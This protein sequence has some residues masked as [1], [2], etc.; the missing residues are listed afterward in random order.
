MASSALQCGLKNIPIELNLVAAPEPIAVLSLDFHCSKRLCNLLANRITICIQVGVL[1]RPQS[2][3]G[4]LHQSSFLIL[5]E[6]PNPN[7]LITSYLAY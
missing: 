3:K 4:P 1:K 5:T 6:L 7:P 2:Y